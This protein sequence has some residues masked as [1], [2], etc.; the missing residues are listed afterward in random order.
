MVGWI[1][2]I[3]LCLAFIFVSK[4]QKTFLVL[5]MLS[6]IALSVHSL[7]IND[8]VFLA[9]NGYITIMC[10]VGLRREY[11]KQKPDEETT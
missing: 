5:D 2:L 10:I 1:G 4:K 11:G 9:V 7:M 3:F 8:M 6:C